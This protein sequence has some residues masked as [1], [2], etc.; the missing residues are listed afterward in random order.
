MKQTI[1]TVTENRQI[2]D[3][4]YRLV[5]EGDTGAFS[6]AGQFV[7]LSLPG[8]YLRRPFSLCDWAENWA[9]IVYK[10]IGEGTDAMTALKPGARLDALTGLGRGFDLSL[11]GTNPLL[12]GGGVGLPPIYRLCKDLRAQG[13]QVSVALGFGSAKDACLV[14]AFRALG[15]EVS[16]STIDGS[17]GVRGTVLDACA[18]SEHSFFYAC[19]PTAMLKAVCEASGTPGELSLE[20]RMGCGFGACVGCTVFTRSGPQRVCKEGPVFHREVLGW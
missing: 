9:L 2:A 8:F 15:A 6:Q 16:L 14:E 1:W 19:G 17:L 12:I 13:N 5:C 20:E 11:S 10:V 18:P 7:N 3:K 4:T